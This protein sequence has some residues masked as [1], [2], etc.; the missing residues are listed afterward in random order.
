MIAPALESI[1]RRWE[2]GEIGVA[3]EHR[4]S[5]IAGR[6]VGRLSHRMVRRG[7]SRGTSRS[8]RP[9]SNSTVFR[10]PCSPICCAAPGSTASTWAAIFPLEC[11]A[12]E[13]E[14]LERLR[15][16]V[17]TA[18]TSGFDNEVRET[19]TRSAAKRDDVPIYVGGRAVT[20]ADHAATLEADGYAPDAAGLITLLAAQ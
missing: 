6:V 1:G 14:K 5:A 13:V 2:A 7:Q 16:V 17:V 9:P 19:V 15:A 20:G 4:A 11:F 18:T 10:L 3:A 12:D 8:A